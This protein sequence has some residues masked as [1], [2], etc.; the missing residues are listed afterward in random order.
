MCWNEKRLTYLQY[1]VNCVGELQR[2]LASSNNAACSSSSGNDEEKDGEKIRAQILL[3]DDDDSSS[4]DLFTAKLAT[5]TDAIELPSAV[6]QK[7]K[8]QTQG[9]MLVGHHLEDASSKQDNCNFY[10]AAT[11][12]T[13]EDEEF[14]SRKKVVDGSENNLKGTSRFYDDDEDDEARWKLPVLK[15]EDLGF[16]SKFCLSFSGKLENLFQES[17]SFTSGKDDNSPADE[18]KTASENKA[19]INLWSCFRDVFWSFCVDLPVTGALFLAG[20]Q[21]LGFVWV[22]GFVAERAFAWIVS[23]DNDGDE[24]A[25]APAGVQ[26]NP[27][28]IVKHRQEFHEKYWNCESWI[29]TCDSLL[30]SIQ[31][32]FA[33]ACAAL[34]AAP[35]ESGTSTRVTSAPTSEILNQFVHSNRGFGSVA[36]S[37]SSFWRTTKHLPAQGN[38]ERASR[39]G[40]LLA[41]SSSTSKKQTS[42]ELIDPTEERT[43]ITPTTS[44]ES[45]N[46]RPVLLQE[47]LIL[48]H[49]TTEQKQ[50]RED[51]DGSSNLQQERAADRHGSSSSSHEQ[52]PAASINN[53]S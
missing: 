4:S 45:S 52:D 41:T 25:E 17:Y 48:A 34:N 9:Q 22:A 40:I 11:A 26:I 43:T 42:Q 37:S 49:R 32:E 27:G 33:Q 12:W 44:T 19:K 23:T 36:A 31:V 39:D 2:F 50:K 3:R 18:D 51:Q 7:A 15:E 8:E 5:C 21:L 38:A 6:F 1:S 29:K 53:W 16:F 30:A 28:K 14:W 47:D 46:K 24:D 13:K 35:A 10:S 20:L